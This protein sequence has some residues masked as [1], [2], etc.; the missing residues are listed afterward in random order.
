MAVDERMIAP[1]LSQPA[2]PAS[3]GAARAAGIDLSPDDFATV[4]QRA[5][6][7]DLCVLGLRFTGDRAVPAARFEMLRRE[8]GEAFTA[9][10]ID[11]SPGNAHGIPAD[12]HSVLTVELV[13]EPG[14]RHG[15]RS[16]PSWTSTARD[17]SR[18]KHRS[19][20]DTPAMSLAGGS[21]R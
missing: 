4:K 3:M 13:D 19:S 10:E 7:G 18:C 1:V 15:T 14:H 12:A 6:A 20:P 5:A 8:L 2:N 21:S 16:M 17:C 9:V 11:S